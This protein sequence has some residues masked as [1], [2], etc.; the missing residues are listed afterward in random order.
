[1][2]CIWITKNQQGQGDHVLTVRKQHGS[3]FGSP[4]VKW[5]TRF[6]YKHPS[7][8]DLPTISSGKNDFG[9]STAGEGS[10]V[11][12]GQPVRWLLNLG[13]V[14]AGQTEHTL[15]SQK[16][17]FFSGGGALSTPYSKNLTFTAQNLVASPRY[18][19]PGLELKGMNQWQSILGLGAFYHL[20]NHSLMF[21][22]SEDLLTN[23]SE[24]FSLILTWLGRFGE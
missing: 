9:I 6:V 21:G 13:I 17:T 24:D 19:A 5:N 16:R 18:R 2:E 1:E 11:W 20:E 8:G 4:K 15:Y 22:F 7:A 12:F 23:H 14:H 3:P 10:E